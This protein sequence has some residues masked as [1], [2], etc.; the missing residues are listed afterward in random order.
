MSAKGNCY[1]N[2]TAEAFFSSFKSDCLPPNNVF[3]SKEQARLE[4]FEYLEVYYNRKRLHSSLDYRTPNEF[5]AQ[6]GAPV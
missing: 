4:I 2:A 6:E 3:A 1:D 5:E